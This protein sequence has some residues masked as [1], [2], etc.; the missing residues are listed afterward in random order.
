MLFSQHDVLKHTKPSLAKLANVPNDTPARKSWHVERRHVVKNALN[1]LGGDGRLRRLVGLVGDSGAGKTTA[2]SEIVRSTETRAVFS[3]GILWLTVNDGAKDRLPSLMLQ[4]ARMVYEDIGGS[5]GDPP[6]ASGDGAAYVQRYVEKGCGGVPYKCLVVADNVWEKEVVSSLLQTGT[7]VLLSTRNAELVAGADGEVVGVGQLSEADAESL[8]RKAA[9]LS[10]AVRLPDDAVTLIELCGRVA[11]DL[12]FVGRWSTVRGRKDRSAWSDAAS[13]L[14]AAMGEAATDSRHNDAVSTHEK[15]R[16]AILQA[17]FEDLAIGSDDERV[18]RLYLSLAV[19]PDAWLFTLRHAAILLYD[20]KPCDDDEASVRGVME[21]LERWTILQCTGGTY[22]MHDA[23]AK[24]ARES[25]MERGDVLRPA[26]KR[27]AKFVSSLEALWSFDAHALKGLWLAVQRVGGD[28]WNEPRPYEAALAEM[29]ESDPLLRKSLEAVGC[30][31]EAQEDWEGASTM[32]RWLLEVEKRELGADHPFV[33]NSYA[34]LAE[35]SDR[36]GNATEATMWREKE[37][38]V[39]LLARKNVK[40]P[41]GHRGSRQSDAC[42]LRSLAATILKLTPEDRNEAEQH[43]RRS[44]DIQQAKPCPDDEE[45]AATLHDLGLCIRQAGGRLEESQQL[46]RRGLNI[47][48]AKLGPDHGQLA[49]T[50]HELG[51]CVRQEGRLE[52]A[53]QLL[54]RCLSIEEGRLSCDDTQVAVTL[55]ALGVCVRKAGRLEE[56]EQLLRRCL[57]ISEKRLGSHDGQLAV[58]LYELGLCVRKAGRLEEAEQLLRRG[59][60]ISEAKLG[61]DHAQLAVTVYELGVCLRMS[62][63]VEEAQRMLNHG[64]RINDARLG[65]GDDHVGVPMSELRAYGREARRPE[66]VG[67]PLRRCLS[68]EKAKHGAR[69]A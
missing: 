44:L 40:Q 41:P 23:H 36:L 5:V 64:L 45:L 57:T 59:L 20:R 22:R 21:V 30:L 33:A 15:R 35:S 31:Q 4:L 55:N 16:K 60:T 6:S 7:W 47:C 67:Q 56:A 38:Q 52:E 68:I 49:S 53:E 63:R 37:H 10:P 2:A 66:E 42:S 39:L 32:W 58:I 3:D 65:P 19:M 34:S 62:G 46:L 43:L 50:L 27:W 12:A 28:G 25:L 26:I 61:P 29:D 13:K 17:G 24:F 51:L 18:Q 69:D 11:M 9:E 1:A 14:R 8:L 48:E 54:R